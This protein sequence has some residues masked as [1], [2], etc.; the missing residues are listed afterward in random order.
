MHICGYGQVS[1]QLPLDLKV[2]MRWVLGTNEICMFA[3]TEL[4]SDHTSHSSV[5]SEIL[6]NYSLEGSKE[7]A[8]E[9][10]HKTIQWRWFHSF[11]HI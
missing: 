2:I 3:T 1:C 4:S 10:R 6:I 9:G 8:L 7:D 5:Y 11:K